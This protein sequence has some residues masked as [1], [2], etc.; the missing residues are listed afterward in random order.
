L[1]PSPFSSDLHKRLLAGPSWP[2]VSS[3]SSGIPF[4]SLY[5]PPQARTLKGE[6][7]ADPNRPARRGC[8]KSRK[9]VEVTLRR[10]DA[11]RSQTEP[12]NR[13]NSRT[14]VIATSEATKHSQDLTRS[15][16]NRDCFAALAITGLGSCT[17]NGR[18][19]ACHVLVGWASCRPV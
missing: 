12:G 16:C 14:T 10:Q 8:L 11:S 17:H 5:S 3:R 19:Q 13:K 6:S 15:R 1:R 7:G 2:V 9:S 4:G 18:P